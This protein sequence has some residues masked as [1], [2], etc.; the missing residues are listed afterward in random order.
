MKEPGR[1]KILEM[2]KTKGVRVVS[3]KDWLTIDKEEIRRGEKKG[4]PREKITQVN[5]MLRCISADSVANNHH[6]L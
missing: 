6:N 3:F 2:L 5:E 4:K 1:R